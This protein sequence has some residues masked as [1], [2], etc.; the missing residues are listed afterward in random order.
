[1]PTPLFR[2][3]LAATLL[4]APLVGLAPDADAQAE[5]TSSGTNRPAS[6]IDWSPCEEEATAECGTVTV[7]IDWDRSRGSTI[8]VAVIRRKATNPRERL[9]SL[10]LN[11]G[12]PGGSG[13]DVVL[14]AYDT[15]P[16]ELLSRYDLV[17]FDPRGV[18]RSH[19][20]VCSQKLTEAVLSPIVS[21]EKEFDRAVRSSGRLGKDCRRR[22]G[23]L[24]DH[25]DTVSV[26][27]DVDAIRTALGEQ[28]I[29]FYGYSYGTQI[30][31][32]YAELYGDRL[33]ALVVDSTVDHSLYNPEFVETTSAAVEDSF[34]EFA[35]WCDRNTA[36]VLHDQGIR[37]VWR[38]LKQKAAQ[39]AL[40]SPYEPGAAFGTFELTTMVRSLLTGPYWSG[41]AKIMAAMDSGSTVDVSGKFATF[42]VSELAISCQDWDF[43]VRDY[44]DYAEYV[45]QAQRVAEDL[46]P[47]PDA[48]KQMVWCAGWPS[49]VSNPQHRLDVTEGPKVLVVNSLHDPATSYAWARNVARQLGDRAALITYEGWGHGSFSDSSCTMN[50]IVTYLTE[51]TASARNTGCPAVEPSLE[52]QDSILGS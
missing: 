50:A 4:I 35:A 44:S 15:F 43:S 25:V 28:K 8:D 20:I 22:T 30:G 12:G 41:L 18:G 13:V 36:C 1:M 10:V 42:T 39:G 48:L 34:D 27:H 14:H 29:A 37:P 21:S 38:S 17:S 52:Y 19:P 9:G 16:K 26:V 3:A 23:P 7:P 31:L 2:G 5:V 24:F 33:S 49:K 46:G 40:S 45:E 32:Q 51:D 11:P 47:S 6:T